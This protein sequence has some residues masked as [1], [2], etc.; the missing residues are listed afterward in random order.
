[1]NDFDYDAMQKK[2][3]AQGARHKKN[4]SKS[5]GCTMPSDHMTKAQKAALNGPTTTILLNQPMDWPTF[6]GISDSLKVTYIENL[7]E[8]YSA[9][10]N[11]LAKMF[12]VSGSAARREMNRLG[13]KPGVKGGDNRSRWHSG[14][15]AA[16]E[17]FCNGVVGGGVTAPEPEK[18]DQEPLEADG[19]EIAAL[20]DAEEL[21]ESATAS[22]VEDKP[23]PAPET[24]ESE[25]KPNALDMT[26]VGWPDDVT[27]IILRN[28]FRGQSVK[29]RI[30]AEVI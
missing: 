12:G 10:A 14:K 8:T 30:S 17:A 9:N 15:M 20:G 28:M 23:V 24:T 6:R 25:T 5:K 21:A 27:M 7:R 13:L 29:V 16:W 3:I 26:F 2:R 11:M 4:G 18:A 22:D 19:G 1:M